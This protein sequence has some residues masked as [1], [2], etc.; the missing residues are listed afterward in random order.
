MAQILSREFP[1]LLRATLV[2][3]FQAGEAEK[4]PGPPEVFPLAAPVRRRPGIS[5]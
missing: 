1:F 4:F 2:P 3:G 5:Q